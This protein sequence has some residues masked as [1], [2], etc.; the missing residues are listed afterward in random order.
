M[1]SK[2]IFRGRAAEYMTKLLRVIKFIVFHMR[3]KIQFVRTQR[4]W[5]MKNR[6]NNTVAG[7]SFWV[8][9]VSVGNET[10]GT[11]FVRNF[12]NTEY[13]LRIGSFCSIADNVIFHVQDDHPTNMISTFPFRSRI[14]NNG[15][16]DA[17]SK[18]S[19]N[20][21][22]DVWIGNGA[23]ILSGVNVGQGAIIAAGA[24]VTKD[25]EPYA[26]VG[27]YLLN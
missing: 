19:I 2:Y 13:R 7:N 14:L 24:V 9:G 5:R 6:H 15:G 8:D 12:P 3:K 16:I 21:G 17:I 20:I 18:G 11:L 1:E 26:I 22:D 25:V 27:G 23:R 10:Y 4:V